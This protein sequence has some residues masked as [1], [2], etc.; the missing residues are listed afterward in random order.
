MLIRELHLSFHV[1]FSYI[2]LQDR[3]NKQY[4]RN[5]GNIVYVYLSRFHVVVR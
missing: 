1:N 3:T 2:S 5:E 4:S